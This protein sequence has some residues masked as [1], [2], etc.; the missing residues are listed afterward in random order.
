MPTPTWTLP[1]DWTAG[2][3]VTA[4]QLNTYVG[5]NLLYLYRRGGQQGTAFPG[6]PATGDRFFRTDLLYDCVYDGSRWLTAESELAPMPRYTLPLSVTGSAGLWPKHGSYARYVTALNVTYNVQTTN[7]GSN[8]WTI[9]LVRAD[10]GGALTSDISTS[11]ASPGVWTN[12]AL[13]SLNLVTGSYGLS[14]VTG[15]VGAPGD[16]FVTATISFRLIIT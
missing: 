1:P 11:A 7:N 12:T 6:S 13:S 16:L 10:T 2:Q 8:Y 5:N 9:K 4:G 15:K 14:L 3:L